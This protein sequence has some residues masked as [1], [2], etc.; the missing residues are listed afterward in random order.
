VIG[1]DFHAVKG[2]FFDKQAVKDRVDEATRRNL[3]TFGSWVRRSAQH[4]IRKRKR[5]ARP[6]QPP[7]SQ[8][9]LLKRFIFFAYD[10]EKRAVVIGPVRLPSQTGEAPPAL[11]YGGATTIRARVFRRRGGQNR[12]VQKDVRKIDIQPR[13]YMGPA[14]KQ[15]ESKL[16]AVWR[17][18]VRP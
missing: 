9:G 15:N 17:D 14:L 1:L 18:S 2:V 4:L 5:P 13:P 7:T 8:T 12:R 10:I 6:G 11:E 3:A 16:P